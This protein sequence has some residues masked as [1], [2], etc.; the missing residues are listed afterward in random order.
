MGAGRLARLPAPA[1]RAA[2][3]HRTARPF[4]HP[5]AARRRVALS[6]G[7]RHRQAGLPDRRAGPRDPQRDRRGGGSRAGERGHRLLPEAAHLAPSRERPVVAGDVRLGAARRALRDVLPEPPATVGEPGAAGADDPRGPRP[8][9][10]Q[11][12]GLSPRDLT[13]IHAILARHANAPV[14]PEFIAPSRR[15]GGRLGETRGVTGTTPRKDQP[16]TAGGGR[17]HAVEALPARSTLG[18]VQRLTE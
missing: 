4:L 16:A 8:A 18:D 2:R 11:A 17:H 9:R 7:A 5:H 10:V 14:G 3:A 13:D 15:T 12:A 6:M 1:R